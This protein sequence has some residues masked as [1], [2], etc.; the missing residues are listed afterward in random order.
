LFTSLIEFDP[1]R[2]FYWALRAKEA[3]ASVSAK[4]A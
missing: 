3:R 2:R 1:I 4:S